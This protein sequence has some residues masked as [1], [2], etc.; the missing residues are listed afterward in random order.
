MLSIGILATIGAVGLG[1]LLLFLLFDGI[2]DVFGGEPVLPAAGFF[3]AVF[4]FS[5]ALASTMVESNNAALLAIPVGVAVVFTSAFYVVYRSFRLHAEKDES[6][7]AD[8]QTLL[9]LTGKVNWWSE[10]SGEVVV[11]WQGHPRK[12]KA[13]SEDAL[14]STQTVFVV[15][16]INENVVKVSSSPLPTN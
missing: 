6:W 13:S 5:G 16:V 7:I 15:E 4:G 9:G 2:F 1:F 11:S 10:G 3:T 8:P 12:L 14:R